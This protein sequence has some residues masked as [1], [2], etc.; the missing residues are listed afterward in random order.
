MSELEGL[1]LSLESLLDNATIV[2]TSE[3]L[4]YIRRS[5]SGG[6]RPL[7]LTIIRLMML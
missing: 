6:E 3:L 7:L 2:H 5:L 4:N 1:L